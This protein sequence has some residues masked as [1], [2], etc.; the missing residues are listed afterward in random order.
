[1]NSWM[2]YLKMAVEHQASDVFFVAGRAACEKLD[3]RIVPM[4]GEK[5]TPAD[6]ERMVEEMYVSAGRSMDAFRQRGD[7]DFSFVNGILGSYVKTLSRDN[8]KGE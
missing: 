8:S 2:D 5:L 6:T 4:P 7:D 1:M 3:G